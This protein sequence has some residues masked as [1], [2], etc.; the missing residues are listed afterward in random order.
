MKHGIY[1]KRRVQTDVS[2]ESMTHQSFKAE[3]DIRNIMNQYKRTGVVSHMTSV[4][5][6]Y[7][8]FTDVPDFRESLNVVI[9][10]EEAFAS[11]PASIR[12]RFA[13]DPA[14]LLDFVS[15][16]SNYDEAVKL[17]LIDAS[18][19]NEIITKTPSEKESDPSST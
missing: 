7:G 15:D 12:K 4:R 11:L 6:R 13:N 8:D 18:K 3:C 5:A 17:G 9:E 16:K 2:G 10:A 1:A 19:T 14:V